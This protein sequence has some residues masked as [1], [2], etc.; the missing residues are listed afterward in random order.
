MVCPLDPR[1]DR[2]RDFVLR[3]FVGTDSNC[4]AL[5]V[6]EI[7][8]FVAGVVGALHCEHPDDPNQY[9]SRRRGKFEAIAGRRQA[10]SLFGDMRRE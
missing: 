3:Q 6:D 5:A 9:S 2:G 4:F 10:A 7:S 8:G 1:G